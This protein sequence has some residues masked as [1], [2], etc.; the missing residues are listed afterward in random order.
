MK[1]IILHEDK[2]ILVCHKPAGLAVENAAVGRMDMVSE[3]KNYLKSSYLGVVH[4]LDQPVEGL[5]VF[6]KN[7]KAAADLSKQLQ[8]NTLNKE[9]FAVVCGKPESNIGKLVDYLAKDNKT[10]M[11]KVV[12]KNDSDAKE[13]IL[14]Y[15]VMQTKKCCDVMTDSEATGGLP[16]NMPN[17]LAFSLLRVEIQTGR[18]HQIRAQL[19]NAGTPILGDQKYGNDASAQVS[20]L[21]GTRNVALCACSL[22]FRH[23]ITGRDMSF[24]IVPESGAF[25]LFDFESKS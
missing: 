20:Q 15:E 23:P 3:L 16:E 25:K 8:K 21:T 11:A 12:N 22:N 10:R 2:D 13:A 9:Y 19:S 5:L 18:F 17:D 6:A 1:T 14:D 7:Q 24:E 4:R